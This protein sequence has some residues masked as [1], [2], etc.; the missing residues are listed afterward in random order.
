MVEDNVYMKSRNQHDSLL[1]SFI[2][3]GVE[4]LLR[5]VKDAT[6]STLAT[7]VME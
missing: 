3:T 4:H 7:E 6:I 1:L 5:D 2:Y